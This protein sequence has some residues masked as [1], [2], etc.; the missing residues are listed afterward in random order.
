MNYYY[1]RPNRYFYDPYYS[2]FPRLNPYYPTFY[3]SYSSIIFGSQ[4]SN[5]DQN[6]VNFGVQ[7]GVSQINNSNQLMSRGGYRRF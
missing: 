4:I 3:P 6:L 1:P 2:R 7:S 5:V